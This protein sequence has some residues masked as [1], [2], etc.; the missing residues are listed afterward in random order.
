MDAK[1]GA[2]EVAV[3]VEEVR[4]D[5]EPGVDRGRTPTL[6]TPGARARNRAEPVDQA[7]ADAVAAALPARPRLRSGHRA[8]DRARAADD[9]PLRGRGRPSC[10]HGGETPSAS[11][12]TRVLEKGPW[13]RRERLGAQVEPKRLPKRERG[14]IPRDWG[15]NRKF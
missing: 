4:F 1:L 12:R 8:N 11:A 14:K 5:A 2:V 6:A 10:P 15:P 13:R 9:A 7:R 3:E